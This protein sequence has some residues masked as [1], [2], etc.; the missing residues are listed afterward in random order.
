MGKWVLI[1]EEPY[2]EII[3]D[4]LGSFIA[5]GGKIR[6][7]ARYVSHRRNSD[8]SVSVMFDD[9]ST[10]RADRFIMSSGQ[11]M[12]SLGLRSYGMSVRYSP[13]MVVAPAICNDNLV[14]V[15]GADRP[16]FSHIVHSYRGINYSVVSGS[17][18]T[19]GGCVEDARSAKAYLQAVTASYF[20]QTFKRRM[21]RTFFGSKFDKRE[22]GEGGDG[23]S[24]LI[25]DLEEGVTAA[26][27][28]KFSFAFLLARNLAM[29]VMN[30]KTV[31][32]KRLSPTFVHPAVIA[33]PRHEV[34]AASLLQASN[35]DWRGE[36]HS[37][38]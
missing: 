22:N 5:N 25:V 6:L 16:S 26:L 37:V 29:K 2:K 10:L 14:V 17:Y 32:V 31:P 3:R 24:P 27:P 38:T 21:S 8:N 23:Y 19:C 13:I 34:I 18:S 35:F 20:P 4:L 33:T 7:A 28:G 11:Q 9:N 36:S 30:G 12:A 15:E 1:S